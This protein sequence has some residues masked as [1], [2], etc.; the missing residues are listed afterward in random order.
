M[1]GSFVAAEIV[2]NPIIVGAHGSGI[3]LYIEV[4]CVFR[5]ILCIIGRLIKSIKVNKR[6]IYMVKEYETLFTILQFANLLLSV[7]SPA[8]SN[9]SKT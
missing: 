5:F 2:V 4:A 3:L 1:Q 7:K 8:P 6:I 9:R